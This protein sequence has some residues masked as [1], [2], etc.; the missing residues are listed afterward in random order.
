MPDEVRT[1]PALTK[2][3]FEAMLAESMP[4]VTKSGMRIDAMDH[5]SCRV[6]VSPDL[7]MA[8]PGGTLSGPTM[9]AM[10]DLALYGAV[11]SMIG[12]V[13]LAVT[14]H[15]TINFLRKPAL[16]DLIAEARV[17]RLGKKLAYGEILLHSD[18]EADPVAHATGAYAIP[19][20]RPAPGGAGG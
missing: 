19:G 14:S 4:Q 1:L 2:E 16:K 20:H 18:G 6:R 5:G 11:L 15:M 9:F 7:H 13:P 17:L 10:A 3:G 8:R 12:P